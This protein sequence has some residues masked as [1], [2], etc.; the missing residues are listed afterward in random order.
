MIC[1]GSWCDMKDVLIVEDNEEAVEALK[2]ILLE[3]QEDVKIWVA[4]NSESAKKI[5]M[6]CLI[7]IFIVDI[8]LNQSN[9]ND[10]SGLDFIQFLRGFKR[11][12]YSPVVITTAVMEP[13]EY[14]Y[15]VLDCY[16]YLEKP[17]NHDKAFQ[18]IEKALKMPLNHDEEQYLHIRSEGIVNIIKA[19][20]IV[21]VLYGNRKLTIYTD[22]GAIEMYYMSLSS[23][24]KQLRGHNFVRCNQGAIVN[25]DYVE[26]VDIK[27][28][29]VYLKK[30]YAPI[31]IGIT[32][33]R[34]VV[35]A[36]TG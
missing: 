23:I 31:K 27:A 29:R 33:K 11:Y 25:K 10:A 3:I 15:D 20:D 2:K 34:E 21:C 24:Q 8:I 5:A 28:N 16:K 17:Y 35:D 6:D 26:A 9:P 1:K 19:S 30:P 4:Y 7:D 14:A 12:E 13:K 32:Y 18:V 22:R 36:L